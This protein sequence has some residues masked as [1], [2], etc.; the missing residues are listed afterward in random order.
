MFFNEE[1]SGY[2]LENIISEYKFENNTLDTVGSNN[3]TATAITYQAGL[4]GQTAVLNGTSSRVA[5]PDANDLSFGDGVNDV[6]FSMSFLMSF[7]VR[8]GVD[9]LLSKTGSTT[10]R[11]YYILWSAQIL[12]LRLF[13]N[14]SGSI[15]KNWDIAFNPPT[16]QYNHISMTY[17]GNDAKIYVGGI[18]RTT[19]F[20]EVGTYVA[21]N[22][23]NATP[24]IGAFNYLSPSLFFMVG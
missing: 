24:L 9:V 10:D 11:E 21:M 20:T 19:T 4:V 3:G 16:G 15:Y 6:P 8:S 1:A 7:R 17:D 13:G 23:L 5:L 12:R 22:N 2:P 18:E 14:T